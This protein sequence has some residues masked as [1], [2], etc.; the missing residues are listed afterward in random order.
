MSFCDIKKFMNNLKK[1]QKY[2][3]FTKYSGN[4]K[5]ED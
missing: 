3:N 4:S 1:F 2:E 5:I